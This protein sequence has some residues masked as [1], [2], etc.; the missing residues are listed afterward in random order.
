MPHPPS[1]IQGKRVRL[2]RSVPSDAEAVFAV[3]ADAEVMRFMDWRAHRDIHETQVFFSGVSE[4][5]ESG[6]EYHWIIEEALTARFVGCIA[7]RI[8]GHAADFGYF[9][10][11]PAWGDG[12]AT[13]AASLVVD[14][15]K[16]Q[17][18]VLRIW[19]TTDFENARS[20]KLLEG[21]GLER[22]GLLRMATYR[23]NI[24]GLPRDTKV[25]AWI[26][27]IPEADADP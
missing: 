12:F 3:A 15:L 26:K 16:A 24:G 25:Y 7:C 4:R 13:E 2:R 20:A 27:N 10:A 9:L 5:W 17:P 1:L 18:K 11:R 19:A 23:P 8:K 6:A 22:E 14:L 21:L